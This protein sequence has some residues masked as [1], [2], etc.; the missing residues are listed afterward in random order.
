MSGIQTFD[1]VTPLNT[2]FTDICN[3]TR[4]GTEVKQDTIRAGEWMNDFNIHDN[5]SDRHIRFL[6]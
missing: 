5:L 3:A 1:P 4:N 2:P 6:L